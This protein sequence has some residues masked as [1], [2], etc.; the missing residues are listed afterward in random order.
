MR[1][2]GILFILVICITGGLQ[3]QYLTYKDSDPEA[4]ALLKKAGEPF[5]GK[6]AEIR[7]K[8]KISIPEQ[9]VVQL[10][11]V[12]YQQGKSYHLDL[13][14]YTIISDGKTRWVY[15]KTVNEVNI[16]NESAGQ[17][18]LSPQDFL[19]L[20]NSQDLVFMYAGKRREMDIIEAK[21]IQGGR[22]DEFA[23]FTIGIAGNTLK[24]INGLA[25]DGIRQEVIIESVTHPASLDPQ[26]WFTFQPSAF[27]G[28]YVEDLRLD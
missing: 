18:W 3:A 27:P 13:R 17:D 15:L 24:M 1:Y 5:S 7:F 4:I 21:P 26:K 22:F 25:S 28:V 12:L 10:D 20:Y 9:E 8:L 19:R 2:S 16:Y 23:K 6:A 11:G 14:D